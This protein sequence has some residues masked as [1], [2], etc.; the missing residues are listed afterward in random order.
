MMRH[1]TI[2]FLSDHRVLST[3]ASSSFQT[4]TPK[5]GKANVSGGMDDTHF[6][7]LWLHHAKYNTAYT[8]KPLIFVVNVTGNRNQRMVEGGG[9]MF[10]SVFTLQRV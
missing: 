5:H 3:A 9:R 7:Q 10:H 1:I 4:D 6:R 8:R 2:R